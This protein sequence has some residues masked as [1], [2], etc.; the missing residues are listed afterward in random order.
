MRKIIRKTLKGEQRMIPQSD[1]QRQ[2]TF[3]KRD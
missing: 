3:Q 2:K 1:K